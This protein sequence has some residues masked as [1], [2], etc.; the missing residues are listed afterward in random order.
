[1][2]TR[3]WFGLLAVTLALSLIVFLPLLP[4][5]L[6][7]SI[8]LLIFIAF[9][10]LTDNRRPAQ[11]Q[12]PAAVPLHQI[13][14]IHQAQQRH[15]ERYSAIASSLQQLEETLRA[16]TH[17]LTDSFSGM[18]AKSNQTHQQINNVLTLVAGRGATAA[19]QGENAVT[20]EVFANEVSN[21]LSQYVGLLV[22][23]SEKSVQAVHHIHDMVN[24]LE[25]MFSLL[26]DIRTI[27]DQTNLLALNA[28][29]EAARAGESGRGFAVVADEV[30]KLSKST[31]QLSTQI[32]DRA[33]RAKS[34]ITEVR[35]IVGDIASLDLNDAINAKGHIDEMLNTLGTMN[36][37]ISVAMERLNKLNTATNEDVSNAIRA[38]QFEDLTTQM[39]GSM[40]TSLAQLSAL[41]AALARVTASSSLVNGHTAVIDELETLVAAT[42]TQPTRQPNAAAANGEIDLF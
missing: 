36:Q 32:R 19:V 28:A 31:E 14:A 39:I 22:D 6:L 21:I 4:I 37:E 33:H 8:L 9:F 16:S 40:Q 27:A 11:S 30:R 38:L 23:V 20:I 3:R 13:P 34:T 29:I 5:Q 1:M 17:Q 10:P 15:Q 2:N 41:Q 42:H 26:E 25:A 24:E 35:H 12:L 7:A 18:G